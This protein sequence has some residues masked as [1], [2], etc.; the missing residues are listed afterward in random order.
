MPKP[1]QALILIHGIGEQRPMET[2]RGFVD[3]VLPPRGRDGIK[4]YSRPELLSDN[5]ELRRLVSAGG[6]DGH[7]DF[8][9]FYWA[10]L[11]PTATWDRLVGW[12]WVLMWR[13][14]KDVPSQMRPLWL[15]SLLIAISIF[16]AGS[17][18]VVRFLF[19]DSIVVGWVGKTPWLIIAIGTL[20]STVVRSYVG[21]AAIYLSPSPRNIEARQKIRSEG[22][23]LLDRIVATKRYDRIII[24]GHSLGSVIGYDILTFA[25]QRHIKELRG[26]IS[27]KWL[28]G[29]LPDRDARAIRQ[30]ETFARGISGGCAADWQLETRGVYA[31][32]KANGD[33]WLVSDF[34]T[35]GSPLAHGAMLL[36][37]DCDDFKR[38]AGEYELPLCPPEL[39]SNGKF[40]FEH[41]GKDGKDR[42]QEAIVLNYAA[43]FAVVNWTNL[44]F[45][46]RYLLKGD[47]VGGPVGQL[48]GS[49]IR[50]VKLETHTWLGW[51]AHTHYWLYNADDVDPVVA[52]LPCLHEALDLSRK[53]NRAPTGLADPPKDIDNNIRK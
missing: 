28:K 27:V 21:D 52:P 20:L 22:L 5:L 16:V 53:K 45:P 46:C 36:A 38:R 23:K 31:E 25:W 1:R 15:L 18:E 4:Y 50:D 29:E 13:R 44:Y 49:G 37:K 17:F 43:V 10:H 47:L 19:N 41:E 32:Q 51:L 30:A 33:G 3:A 2:L 11:M 12:Y 24:I 39:D 42:R 34:V 48:F 35:V 14:W 40:S 26:E 9:E 6:R 8:Y 7:S